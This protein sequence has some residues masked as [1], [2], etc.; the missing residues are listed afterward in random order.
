MA[1]TR[2]NTI[3]EF[4]NFE[5]FCILTDNTWISSLLGSIVALWVKPADGTKNKPT[6]HGRF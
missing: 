4:E 1:V 6:K 3:N 2:K 5:V